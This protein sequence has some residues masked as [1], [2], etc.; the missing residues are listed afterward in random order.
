MTLFLKSSHLVPNAE[1]NSTFLA[2]E[3]FVITP[4]MV[5]DNP[6]KNSLASSKL[7]NTSSQDCA[8]PDCTASFVVSHNWVSVFTL[9]AA[10]SALAAI[11]NMSLA[12]ATMLSLPFKIEF[13]RL[14]NSSELYPTV[15][16]NFCNSK[17]LSFV[18][19][20]IC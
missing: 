4:P 19:P 17:T 16:P 14:L 12:E 13:A 8:Q 10:S 2:S 15:S 6:L 3:N 11:P 1:P 20:D 18:T 7:P 5:S 9:V